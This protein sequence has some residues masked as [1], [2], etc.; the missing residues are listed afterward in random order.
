MMETMQL[1]MIRCEI[2]RNS[3]LPGSR[4]SAGRC[5]LEVLHADVLCVA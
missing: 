4:E 2:E 5:T 3:D 1:S